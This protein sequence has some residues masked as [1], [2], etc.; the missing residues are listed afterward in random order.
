MDWI[1]SLFLCRGVSQ[2]GPRTD[3]LDGQLGTALSGLSQ[4]RQLGRIGIERLADLVG[5]L[6][7]GALVDGLKPTL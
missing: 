2:Q 7:G 6:R 5:F 3:G 4:W 1:L